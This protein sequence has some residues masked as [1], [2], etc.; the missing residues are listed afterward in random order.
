MKGVKYTWHG[1]FQQRS[2]HFLKTLKHLLKLFC[3]L[4]FTRLVKK[5]DILWGLTWRMVWGVWVSEHWFLEGSVNNVW[6]TDYL[7]V[8]EGS[9]DNN[10][11][12]VYW[13][14]MNEWMN[15][16]RVT[17]YVYFKLSL[18]QF[19]LYFC[20]PRFGMWMCPCA[21]SNGGR[22]TRTKSPRYKYKF[23]MLW[24]VKCGTIHQINSRSTVP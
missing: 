22:R 13:G 17:F 18:K 11:M 10:N 21:M 14:V 12:C 8:L 23:L 15:G 3:T 2:V 19:H 1:R 4:S 5:E 7:Y 6:R 16:G 20:L 24:I 9:C